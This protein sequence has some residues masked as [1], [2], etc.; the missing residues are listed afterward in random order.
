MHNNLINVIFRLLLT[1]YTEQSPSWE[2]NRFSA[3]QEFPRI[4]WNPRVHYRIHKCPS[5]VPVLSQLHPVH[6]FTSHFLKIYLIIPSTPGSSQVVSFPQVPPPKFC[7]RLSSPPYAIHAPPISFCF[8]IQNVGATFEI[9][10]TAHRIMCTSKPKI[11]LLLDV[12]SSQL[13]NGYWCSDGAQLHHFQGEAVPRRNYLIIIIIIII[14]YWNW[15]VARWQW[16]FYMYT[17]N[18][19]C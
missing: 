19:I 7:I 8:S 14:I 4:L 9:Q 17:E 15:V 1:Y 2:A 18:E 16:L 10:S 13:V 5:P 12:A 11:H 6:T 3:S